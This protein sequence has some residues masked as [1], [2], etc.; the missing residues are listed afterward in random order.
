MNG[1]PPD[2]SPIGRIVHVGE[3]ELALRP[4]QPAD[5]PELLR[6]HATPEVAHWWGEPEPG[7]PLRDE[8]DH[9]RVTILVGGAVAGLLQYWEEPWPRYRHATI[10]LFLDPA[11][12][13]QGIGTKA[14]ELLV[15][16]LISERGHHRL[17]ID[18]ASENAA[19]IRS[20]EKA[21]FRRVGLL[22]AYEH[23]GGSDYRDALLMEKIKENEN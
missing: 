12:H 20:Y 5:A 17:T 1:P 2:G 21:G 4:L 16:H 15:E 11:L 22:R 8:P 3:H 6:I 18:P 19:A 10:D 13:G 7:F 9:T 23:R 14:L